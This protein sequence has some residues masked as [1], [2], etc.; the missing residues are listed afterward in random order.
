MKQPLQRIVW[1][2]TGLLICNLAQAQFV[3]RRLGEVLDEL[4]SQ[5][6]TFIYNTQV[7]PA[8]LLV[9]REPKS[10]RGVALAEELLAEHGLAIS[11][12][13]PNVYAVVAGSTPRIAEAPSSRPVS[14][15]TPPRSS[16]PEEVVVQTSRYTLATDTLDAP[17]FLSQDQVQNMPRLADE[18]LRALQRL[19]GTTTNGFSSLGSVR[20]GEPNETAIVL[21]G[22]RLYEPFHLKNFLS[23]VS[24]LDSRLIDG[25]DFYSGGF[26]AIFGD[27]MSAIIDA[28]SVHPGQSRYYEL[29][30]NLF[31]LSALAATEFDAGRGHLLL[32]GRRSN[33][34][35]LV[36]FSENEFGEPHYSDGFARVDYQ[37]SD[38]TSA[39]MDLLISSD[40]IDAIR[41]KETQRANAQ[42]RNVYVWG[43]LNHDW[44]PRASSRLITSFT[45]LSNERHGTVDDPGRRVGTVSDERLFHVIGLRLEN[46]LEANAITHHFGAEVRRLWGNY[47]YASEL[48][49]EPGFPF[50]GSP[51]STSIR[52]ENPAPRGYESSAYWDA[53]AALGQRWTIQGGLR[54]DTQTYDG[55]DDGEQWSPRLSVLYSLGPRS[56]LRASWGRFFQSQGINEL[57]VEDGVEQFYPA[58]HADHAI[59]GFDH[60]F[61]AGF[62]LRLEA[63]RKYYRHI[64]PRFENVF[65][66][67]VLFPE[68]EF[69]R[70]RI[71]PQSARAVGAELLLRMRPHGAWSGWLSYTWSRAEDRI[72]QQNVARSWDQRH[73][74]NLG[75][76]W[77]SGPWT[78]TLA[79]SF[80]TG[81][82]TTQLQLTDPTST[83][84]QVVLAQRNNGRYDYYNSL[85]F[86]VTRTLVLAHGALDV[87]VEVSNALSRSNPCCAQYEVSRNDD[88]LVLQ[89]EE[90][91][92]LPLVPS[93]GVLWKY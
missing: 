75:I 4:R 47:D 71:D 29:G 9:T 27:R 87:F 67:L 3:G 92:W 46:T 26:P 90:D 49:I 40:A 62:D 64:N 13:A 55:S 58:Q 72:E 84:L 60:A 24:L 19:P 79:D 36:Q 88:A 28:R 5:G 39:A 65:D 25:I 22:L 76:V 7:V 85:D 16:A 69:D 35:D 12:A 68:A 81:W 93:A 18:S 52:V 17:I 48:R 8:D 83:N 82:P 89:R 45:D 38:S 43:T 91:S 32:S 51:G 11:R 53:R 30:L 14:P 34:G 23:P 86:R 20:G 33:L 78:A 37:L 31:H 56:H 59:L 66:P 50:P 15:P 63:Y 54:V 74:I 41:S 6:L 73:A 70:V 42:Y 61:T 77:A 57:Q 80:H 10:A 1:L 2:L 44:S 21:D